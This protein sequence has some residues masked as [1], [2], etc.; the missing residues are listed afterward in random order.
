MKLTSGTY[1]QIDVTP[2]QPVHTGVLD[3]RCHVSARAWNVYFQSTDGSTL[4]KSAFFSHCAY[5]SMTEEGST[6]VGGRLP[7][8]RLAKS[9]MAAGLAAR[10][11][12]TWRRGRAGAYARWQTFKKVTRGQKRRE[13]LQDS[14]P[15]GQGQSWRV[16]KFIHRGEERWARQSC[17][18]LTGR[19]EG[20][21]GRISPG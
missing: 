7:P 8:P 6:S 12:A 10:Q 18:N 5:S 13:A 9:N 15:R 2:V 11:E 4:L 16:E 21:G 19:Q 1:I 20:G 14:C 17:K 3:D